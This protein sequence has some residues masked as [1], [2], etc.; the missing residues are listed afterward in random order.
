MDVFLAF[1]KEK[2]VPN[3]ILVVVVLLGG[4]VVFFGQP[5]YTSYLSSVESSS[6]SLSELQLQNYQQILNEQARLEELSNL[7]TAEI[8]NGKKPKQSQK[9]DIFQSLSK[10][11]KL[12]EEF[13]FTLPLT[14]REVARRYLASLNELRKAVVSVTDD[15]S[16]AVF[17]SALST[18]L[19]A[20]NNFMTVV[21]TKVGV[22]ST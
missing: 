2:K 8:I 19:K 6:R 12:A 10:Q 22:N 11:Y 18:K 14:E 13:Q 17:Y 16:L 1:L 15:K 20:Q 21:R 4:C 3:W 9:Q 5:L 7:F